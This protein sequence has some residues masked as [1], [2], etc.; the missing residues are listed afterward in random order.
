METL[1]GWSHRRLVR[2]KSS[3]PLAELL[4]DDAGHPIRPA[5]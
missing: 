1:V 3:R 2:S 5:T 4:F